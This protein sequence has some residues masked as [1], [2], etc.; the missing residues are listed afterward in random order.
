MRNNLTGNSSARDCLIGSIAV[1]FCRC[2]YSQP[3]A[4]FYHTKTFIEIMPEPDQSFKTRNL[5]QG[6]D[7][8]TSPGEN[9]TRSEQ[10]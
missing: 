1:F 4:F 10:S 9:I 2:S 3:P 8:Q 7:A 6:L 5:L